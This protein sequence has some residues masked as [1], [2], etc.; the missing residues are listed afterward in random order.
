MRFLLPLL[1]IVIPISCNQSTT[2]SEHS[3]SGENMAKSIEKSDAPDTSSD[4]SRVYFKATGTEPF[5]SLQISDDRIK[6][7]VPG[8]SLI[9]PHADPGKTADAKVKYYQLETESTNL[10]IQIFHRECTNAMSGFKFPYAVEVQYKR[11]GDQDSK[12]V[13]GCGEYI[14]DYRLNDVWVL[15]S[16]N[17]KE[18]TKGDFKEPP[19]LE[20][21]TSSNQFM[22]FAGC[23]RMSG[24][25]FFEKKI[26]RFTN[27][28]TTKMACQ[29]GNK[30][31][32]F[33]HALKNTTTYQI[34]NNRLKLD[35]QNAISLVFRK[36]D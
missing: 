9:T 2:K 17:G 32:A 18:I 7:K 5:W 35:N 21:N 12:T 36:I 26:I 34:G 16:L 4:F 1:W 27:I 24:A 28:I 11:T 29:P 10:S 31:G 22:G 25:L 15:E 23:N 14:T 8:D 33:L 3:S 19:K 30:E 20:I 6:F 13:K